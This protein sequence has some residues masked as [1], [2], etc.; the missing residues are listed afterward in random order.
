MPKKVRADKASA[1]IRE[2][3]GPFVDRAIP[4]L[5]HR[6]IGEAGRLKKN[7]RLAG[8][9]RLDIDGAMVG[10]KALDAP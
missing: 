6:G 4:K 2:R 3:P 5:K 1:D 9:W 10:Q 7:T 8:H